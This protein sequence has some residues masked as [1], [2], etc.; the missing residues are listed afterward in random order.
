M[1]F[2]YSRSWKLVS[3]VFDPLLSCIWLTDGITASIHWSTSVGIVMPP[4]PTVSGSAPPVLEMTASSRHCF[5]N[6]WPKPILRV[7]VVQSACRYR[8]LVFL[9]RRCQ[10]AL[11]GL[12]LENFYCLHHLLWS[13]PG[14]PTKMRSVFELFYDFDQKFVFVCPR[15]AGWRYFSFF[16][17]RSEGDRCFIAVALC[18]IFG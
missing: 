10:G 15:T 1:L 11:C 16:R 3:A 2:G 12:L 9:R 6:G 7:N 17:R 8:R 13:G 14:P 5:N 18:G 4:A